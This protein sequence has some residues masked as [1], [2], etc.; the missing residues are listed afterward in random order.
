[1]IDSA[2]WSDLIQLS[3]I[4]WL[5]S[6][7]SV[8]M[9]MRRIW[10][11][12]NTEKYESE[13]SMLDGGAMAKRKTEAGNH[14]K[15]DPVQGYKI[16]IQQ[17]RV[18]V[19]RDVT[20]TMRK[21]DQYAKIAEM[22][23]E[24]GLAPAQRMELDLANFFSYGFASSGAASSYTNLDGEVVNTITG[25][26]ISFFNAAHTVA[27]SAAT[28]SNI[29]TSEFDPQ[30]LALAEAQV[31]F[32]RMLKPSG[33]RA[34]RKASVILTSDFYPVVQNV[35]RL[36]TSASV[37]KGTSSTDTAGNPGMA[38]VEK[39]QYKHEQADYLSN[40]KDNKINT[41]FE[42]QWYLIDEKHRK[43]ALLHVSE[44]PA[45]KDPNGNAEL[46]D[47]A[48]DAV[49]FVTSA[50]YDYGILEGSFI[51]GSTAAG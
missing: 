35:R 48:N 10:D 28:Y 13:H 23:R 4:D 20:W 38:N 27:G 5:E 21:Y 33:E 45:F 41:N 26:G 50:S 34:Q 25:D 30:G 19:A 31:L 2:A 40:D 42:K 14:V 29:I 24:L 18:S 44:E 11:Y 15:S 39:G 1:M 6:F 46:I 17:Q 7:Q 22:M 47:G 51:V 3:K 37:A 8:E 12:Q 32:G 16:T 43:Q 9:Q 36:L 49:T